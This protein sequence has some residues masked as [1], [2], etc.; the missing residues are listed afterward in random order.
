[1]DNK[2]C[3]IAIGDP[4]FKVDNI[5]NVEL[6]ILRITELI[7][8]KKPDFIVVLGDLL[9]T[10]EK[11]D[12]KPL[13][14][15]YQFILGIRE[16]APVYV[17]VGNH[18]MCLGKDIPV[19]LW[20]GETKMS[21]DINIGDILVGDNGSH[22]TVTNICSGKQKMYKI[23]QKNATDYIVSENHILSL[24][25]DVETIDISIK[26]YL[27]MPENVRKQL[28]GFRYS[29]NNFKDE[30]RTSIE[31]EEIGIDDYY[32]FSVD[33]NHRFLLGDFTVTHNCNNQQFLSEEHWMNAM[34]EWDNVYIIDKTI[35]D[36]INDLQFTFIPYVPNG[37]F[38]EALNT[39]KDWVN[40][41]C[42]FS[43]QEI[44]GCK[45][46]AIIS[47]DGDDWDEDKPFII[48]GHIHSRQMV[49]NN[50][51]YTGSA[52]Q[53]AFGESEKNIIAYITFERK[54][55]EITRNIEEIDLQLPRKRIIYKEINEL[56]NFNITNNTTEDN[57]KLTLS[58]TNDEFKTFKKTKKY[59]ELQKQNI[60]I[61]FKP[62]KDKQINS[63]LDINFNNV[64]IK[65]IENQKN[66]YVREIFN[67]INQN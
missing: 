38:I 5:L 40:S 52:M 27:N 54:E 35:C 65:L 32:G 3:I 33:K 18:D 57:I 1:M 63:K 51:Y 43:H 46:G 2:V 39:N 12:T 17:L 21:Q 14:K 34:K 9:H 4:H 67:Q 62:K 64:L 42:I 48:S 29:P 28:Y 47:S 56:K 66:K 6:F 25:S 10:H 59:K 37:R 20:N 19:L 13:N 55:N 23:K 45:M 61:V 58:G 30:L 44:K 7:K 26:D 24:K 60:K 50:V 8:E 49:G 36:T 22:R 41:C 53:H 11:L 16:F 31:V 15:A